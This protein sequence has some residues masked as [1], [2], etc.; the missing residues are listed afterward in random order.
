SAPQVSP[1]LKIGLRKLFNSFL[2]E[3]VV[4]VLLNP[5]QKVGVERKF[6]GSMPGMEVCQAFLKNFSLI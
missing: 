3:P 6:L 2:R 4:Q 5:P 1:E